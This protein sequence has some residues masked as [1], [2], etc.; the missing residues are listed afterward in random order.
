[1]FVSYSVC[2]LSGRGADPSSRGVLPAAVCV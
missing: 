1:M 2:V